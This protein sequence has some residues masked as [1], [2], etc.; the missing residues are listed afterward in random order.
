MKIGILIP[1]RGDRPDFLKNCQRM[2]FS[3]TVWAKEQ[4]KHLRIKVIDF[5]A[6]DERVDITK[7]YR[8]GYDEFRGAGLDVI[9]FMENDDWYAIDYLETMLKEWDKVG[10]PDLFGT[11]YVVYYHLKLRKYFTMRMEQRAMAMNTLIKP[12]LTFAWPMDNDPFTDQWL[13]Q[14]AIQNRKIFEPG[15]LIA[16]GMKHGVGKCGGYNHVSKLERY[17]NDDNGF[18]RNTLDDA[19]YEFYNQ[20]FK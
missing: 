12:D 18:L 14:G 13:W 9:A 7:R 17:I 2:I 5:P 11:N 16:V 8:V 10:R 20:V 1:D 15:H 3:Q 4:V 19:S 6:T